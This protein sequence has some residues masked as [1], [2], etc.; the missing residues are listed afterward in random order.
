MRPEGGYVSLEHFARCLIGSKVTG[1][2]PF[3]EEEDRTVGIFGKLY[4]A[5][6]LDTLE[7]L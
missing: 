1:V 4:D 6:A 7:V 3:L 2:K 5:G